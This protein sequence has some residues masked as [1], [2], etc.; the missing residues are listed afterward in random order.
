MKPVEKWRELRER[1][2][3]AVLAS[4]GVT[5]PGLRREVAGGGGPGG[6][7]G[8]MLGKLRRHA[9]RITDEEIAALRA[10]GES[11]DRLFELMLAASIGDAERRLAAGLAALEDGESS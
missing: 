10:A 9:Y 8:A 6:P 7:L 11:D 2:L 3:D 1:L 5:E 4:R